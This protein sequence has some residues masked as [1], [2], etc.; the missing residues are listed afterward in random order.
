[1][2][3]TDASS[4]AATGSTL[5]QWMTS[6]KQ[7]MTSSMKRLLR[8]FVEIQRNPLP[9]I[10]AAPVDEKDMFLWH[11]NLR[12]PEATPYENAIFHLFLKFPCDYPNSPPTVI[13][14]TSIPHPNVFPSGICLDMLQSRTSSAGNWTSAYTIQSVLIQLQ[15]FLLDGMES[16]SLDRID[17]AFNSKQMDL[18]RTSFIN[19]DDNSD[20]LISRQE[21]AQL[22]VNVGEARPSPAYIRMLWFLTCKEDADDHINFNTFVLI[23]KAKYQFTAVAAEANSFKCA[24][25]KHKPRF[26][27]P[28]FQTTE[29]DFILLSSEKNLVSQVADELVCF[30]T[31]RTRL[32]DCLGFGLSFNRNFRHGS[33]QNVRTD[34]D[35]ISLRAYSK[36]KLR[37]GVYGKQFTH[38]LP[39]YLDA[40]HGAKALYLAQRNLSY[41]CTGVASK[42]TPAQILE[43]YPRMMDT[44][45]AQIALGLVPFSTRVINGYAVVH[46]TLLK[47]RGLH[48][49]VDA[50]INAQIEK[51]MV[52]ETRNQDEFSSL[53]QFLSLLSLSDKY[54]WEDVKGVFVEELYDRWA[55]S[56]MDKYPELAKTDLTKLDTW[57]VEKF[58]DATK[59]GA[60]I[61]AFS[62]LLL[63]Q[64]SHPPGKT[65]KDIESAR[66]DLFGHISP[67]I[68]D[69]LIPLSKQVL[70]LETLE[71]FHRWVEVPLTDSDALLGLVKAA[72]VRS[73]ARGYHGGR[74]VSVMSTEDYVKSLMRPLR[75][76]CIPQAE[77]K[78]L[79]PEGEEQYKQLCADRFEYNVNAEDDDR[80]C[81]WKELFLR[82][83]LENTI[84]RLNENPDFQNFHETLELSGPFIN[85]LELTM[86]AVSNLKSGYFFITALLQKL[87]QL[88]SFSTLRGDATMGRKGMNAVT[89]G[90]QHNSGSLETIRM[91]YIGISSKEMLS[92]AKGLVGC[93]NLKTLDLSGNAIGVEG[94]GTLAS[95]L[96]C[97]HSVESICLQHCWIDKECAKVLAPSFVQNH[98]LKSINLANNGMDGGGLNSICEALAYSPTIT[99]LDLSKNDAST[100]VE[101][102][103][104]LKLLVESSTTLETLNLYRCKLKKPAYTA[105]FAAIRHARSLKNLD[106]AENELPASHGKT[107]F[108]SLAYNR[109]LETLHFEENEECGGTMAEIL[110]IL[111]PDE[112]R[113]KKNKVVVKPEDRDYV[114]KERYLSLRSLY[115]DEIDMEETAPWDRFLEKA[116]QLRVL[117]LSYCDLGVPAAELLGKGLELNTSV[118]DINLSMNVLGEHG[119]R[120]LARGL[121]HNT[122]ITAFD[123]S[124][125][126][127]FAR[128]C[129]HVGS[130]L[131]SPNCRLK[132]LNMFGNSM[133]TEGAGPFAASLAKN[134]SLIE[135][136]LG[137]NRLRDKGLL[138]F[139][140]VV[141]SNTTLQ[142]LGLKTNLLKGKA[143]LGI[144]EA[145]KE[146]ASSALTRLTLAG[147][148]IPNAQFLII[149]DML[150]AAKCR[151]DIA[152]HVQAVVPSRL[153]N[154]VYLGHLPITVTE[155]TIKKFVMDAKLGAYKTVTL[156]SKKKDMSK[157][158]KSDDRKFCFIEFLDK[159]S[160]DLAL[161]LGKS[162]DGIQ[163]HGTRCRV[164]R[165]GT[166]KEKAAE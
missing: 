131:E 142:T 40:T 130:V 100:S 138:H 148:E 74:N 103:T 77:G 42:F 65:L 144:A 120:R 121:L 154:T 165:A 117:S 122:T 30:H 102:A 87:Q 88:K 112:E 32:E 64:V 80:N 21:L 91:P 56:A 19:I 146:N 15:S 41:I 110:Y 72:C 85:Q 55:H 124:G 141:R 86:N 67:S 108:E 16:L 44:L 39:V 37:I 11:A 163:L 29:S 98:S 60:R 6:G 136:D 28:T 137:Q 58:F 68:E 13:P 107:L 152:D 92:L 14:A 79:L 115:M 132:K 134:T 3:Y 47:L 106:L 46:H 105:F 116:Q 114:Y 2:S 57:R 160:V 159:A 157:V 4:S 10:A 5:P 25:C 36:E 162:P 113:D 9:T 66:D 99:N 22:M 83:Y 52:T 23:M 156:K 109:V 20:G 59:I 153:E 104:S 31:R 155:S 127:L 94:C 54:R 96:K 8:D 81:S 71:E 18:F 53:G 75:D 7:V 69:A 143:A 17:Y 128:G 45:I 166:N 125:N 164:A 149:L 70:N 82:L 133:G 119:A 123:I 95:Y 145:R 135:L 126:N 118:E 33:I 101:V 150:G 147:N 151:M 51:F 35:L 24:M 26:P 90:L 140:P 27:W 49:E 97:H 12:G 62:V 84:S 43:V 50:L 93:P 161:D 73:L 78:W 129:K 1:M 38:W 63:N 89:K 111:N 139:V 76:I 61:V 158:F 34:C 48:A